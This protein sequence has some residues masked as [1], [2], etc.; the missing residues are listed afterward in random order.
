M[1][2][3]YID[4]YQVFDNVEYFK[5]NSEK[6]YV[7]T[8]QN[9]ISSDPFGG[10]CFYIFSFVKRVDDVSGIKKMYHQPRLTK[11]D[12]LPGT[13]LLRVNPKYPEE[14]T[15]IWTLPNEEEFN[16]YKYGKMFEDPFVFECIEK[17]LHNPQEL[18]KYIPGDLSDEQIREIYKSKYDKLARKSE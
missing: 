8:I 11:P 14:A 1:Q 17:Y 13:T 3:F 4:K 10:H 18:T 6:D 16:L 5:Q 7:Q 2:K 9:I 12:P 15:I